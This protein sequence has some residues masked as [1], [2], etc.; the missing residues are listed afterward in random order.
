[1]I[2]IRPM[3]AQTRLITSFSCN[4]VFDRRKQN[5]GIKMVSKLI[6]NPDFI[7]VINL[8]PK[9]SKIDADDKKTEVNMAKNT[10][11]L[12]I[13]LSFFLKTITST[14]PPIKKLNPRK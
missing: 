6:S 11:L 9:I 4:K 7:G 2:S 10:I 12:L 3:N 8:S 1:M 14:I 5:I 13:N